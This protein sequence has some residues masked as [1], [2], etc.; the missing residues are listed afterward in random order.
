MKQYSDTIEKTFVA[1]HIGRGGH[2]HNAGHLSFVDQDRPISDFVGDLFSAYENQYAIFKKIKG[3]ENLEEKYEQASDGDEDGLNF[4]AK[5]GLPFGELEYTDGSCPVG[6]TLEQ[7]NSGIGRINIDHEYD[8]T[9]VSHL[10]DCDENELRL[11]HDDAFVSD[12][13]REYCREALDINNK[14]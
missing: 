11:I 8:T 1:F 2:F 4:F 5:K 9:Y 12:S 10:E 14:E 3:R 7:A 13:V 6:L